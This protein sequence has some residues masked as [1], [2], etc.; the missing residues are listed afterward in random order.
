MTVLELADILSKT[1]SDLAVSRVT[2][3][4]RRKIPL[5]KD[6]IR[7]C[8]CAVKKEHPV[9]PTDVLN[10]EVTAFH[11]L[12]V[13]DKDGKPTGRYDMFIMIREEDEE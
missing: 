4:S 12:E 10:S 1:N 6:S 9:V 5:F 11:M 2:F 3:G 8:Q 13:K 7:L